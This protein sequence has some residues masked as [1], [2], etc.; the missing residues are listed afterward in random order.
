MYSR[1][2]A[3][4]EHQ[5]RAK[6]GAHPITSLI[7]LPPRSGRA[8]VSSFSNSHGRGVSVQAPF[9]RSSASTH[10][11]GYDDVCFL[12]A[13]PASDLRM[14]RRLRNDRNR[15]WRT[16]RRSPHPVR[17]LQFLHVH[18]E[19]LPASAGAARFDAGRMPSDTR[20]N[21]M[22]I[23]FNRSAAQEADLQ[24]LLAAQQDPASPLF[25]KWLT[26]EQYAARFGMSQA[27]IDSV[28]LWLQQQGFSVDSV[29]RSKNMIH[30][31]GNVGQVEM[32]FQTQMH[33]FN[34]D[35]AKH[36]APATELSL[37]A[38]IAPTVAAV[39]NLSD[40]RPKPEYI[41]SE[42]ARAGRIHVEYLRERVLRPRRYQN[43]L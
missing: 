18:F 13:S 36:F 8:T 20:L 38:A 17:G 22:T 15:V 33:Y 19:R 11:D 43:R 25:H 35:G 7:P 23:V 28:S 16:D 14:D 39:M 32:A 40:F 12:K 2:A 29:A 10:K 5:D 37:P 30:F 24:A 4:E 6:E 26:P 1:K 42:Q 21:G 34:V 31:S 41:P 27:D 3:P 9:A